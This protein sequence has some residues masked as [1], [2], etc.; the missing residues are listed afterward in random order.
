MTIS[1]TL[2]QDKVYVPEVPSAR[3]GRYAVRTAVT[4]PSLPKFSWP[5]VF[6][7]L[8]PGLDTERFLRVATVS[9]LNSLAYSPLVYFRDS[10]VNIT[11]GAIPGTK[12][13][14]INPPLENI[15]TVPPPVIE[16][17]VTQDFTNQRVQITNPVWYNTPVA[18]SWQLYDASMLTLI[19]QGTNG[20]YAR[21][22]LTGCLWRDSQFMALFTNSSDAYDHI[23][24]VQADF[25]SLLT[26]MDQ[27][28]TEYASPP[29]PIITAFTG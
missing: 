20:Y 14:I 1:A 10:V 5:L 17:I 23:I 16:T 29:N 26:N 25:Q 19:S 11:T 7:P 28:P 2:T 8:T 3:P 13:V 4:L 9:D 6:G 15:L 12:L 27:S 24:A 22:V 18:M 21:Q